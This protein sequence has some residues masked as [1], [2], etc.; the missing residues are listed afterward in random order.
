MRAVAIWSLPTLVAFG[1]C[2]PAVQLKITP[3][4]AE[5]QT[6]QQLQFT[7]NDEVQWSAEGGT[8]TGEGLYTGRIAP[9]LSG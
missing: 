6:G 3:S 8:I 5:L 2:G 4:F 1:A 7:A 9:A